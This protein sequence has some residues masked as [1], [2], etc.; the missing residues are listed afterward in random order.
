[1]TGSK[2]FLLIVS[3]LLKLDAELSDETIL[4]SGSPQGAVLAHYFFCV[5]QPI[6]RLYFLLNGCAI[7]QVNSMCD[8]VVLVLSDLK[9]TT[10]C[11]SLI[12]RA[13]FCIR[14]LFNTFKGH[15]SDFYTSLYCTYIRPILE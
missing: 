4:L 11:N 7:E 8:V 1:M 2:T 9:F 3:N 10:H 13:H 5:S 6:I 15:N 14:N 12:K